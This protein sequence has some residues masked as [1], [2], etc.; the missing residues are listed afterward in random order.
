M[1][2]DAEEERKCGA[3]Y[4]STNGLENLPV[5]NCNGASFEAVGKY[6]ILLYILSLTKCYVPKET[7]MRETS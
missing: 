4:W 3:G 6:W 2:W 5:P 7:R 1:K